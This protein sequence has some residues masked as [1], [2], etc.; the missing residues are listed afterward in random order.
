M[1]DAVLDM[2]E[3]DAKDM[4]G[5]GD[6][7]SDQLVALASIAISLRRLADAMGAESPFLQSLAGTLDD[8]SHNHQ[9]R[10]RNI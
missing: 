7:A 2:I 1:P 3:P 9:Q 4:A 5:A 8:A 6:G 10:M